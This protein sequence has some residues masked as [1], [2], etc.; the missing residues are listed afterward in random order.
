MKFRRGWNETRNVPGGRLQETVG[1]T[2]D[3]EGAKGRGE[4]EK[5]GQIEEDAE[6]NQIDDR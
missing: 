6:E 3:N 2:K 4:N 1:E 5:S